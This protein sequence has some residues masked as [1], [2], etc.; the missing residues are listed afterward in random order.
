MAPDC[1]SIVLDVYGDGSGHALRMR[2]VDK[3]GKYLQYTFAHLTWVG[4]K[5]VHVNVRSP[6]VS[7]GGDGQ[8]LPT[9]PFFFHCFL[10][11][12]K[13]REFVGT[14]KIYVRNLRQAFSKQPRVLREEFEEGIWT[15]H[16][17]TGSGQA[18]ITNEFAQSGSS[19]L[20]VVFQDLNED[21]FLIISPHHSILIAGIPLSFSVCAYGVFE[22]GYFL[23]ADGEGRPFQLPFGKSIFGQ[24]LS[25]KGDWEHA[26]G[27]SLEK[28]MKLPLFFR[29]FK[30]FPK[31]KNGEFYL[32][33]LV[34]DAL[35]MNLR[36]GCFHYRKSKVS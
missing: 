31:S 1:D 11:E 17:A 32:D 30:I 5:E 23:L 25:L 12:S 33:S 21:D 4:W 20:K 13:S 2:I 9:A 34:C 14:G 27:E 26:E 8:R 29:G 10:L 24:W 28:P 19:S 16:T 36:G 18:F 35:E 6:D 3:T 15:F 7:W 22:R